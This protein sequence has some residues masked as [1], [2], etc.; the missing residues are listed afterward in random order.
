[1]GSYGKE[2]MTKLL[3]MLTEPEYMNGRT[4]VIMV[5]AR[6]WVRMGAC[7]CVCA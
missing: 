1:V 3:G 6:V 7:V 5:R 2:A 4:V